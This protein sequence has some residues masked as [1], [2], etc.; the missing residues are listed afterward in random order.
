MDVST[1]SVVLTNVAHSNGVLE[2]ATARRIL[3]YAVPSV[4]VR[5]TGFPDRPN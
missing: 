4:P 2:K 1:A 3:S 5:Q